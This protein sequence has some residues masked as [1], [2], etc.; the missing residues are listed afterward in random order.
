MDTGRLVRARC[1]PLRWGRSRVWAL[2]V[3]LMVPD[4]IEG[5]AV[6]SEVAQS[7]GCL[8]CRRRLILRS[9]GG[10]VVRDSQAVLPQLVAAIWKGGNGRSR[11]KL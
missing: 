6:K 2:M 8:D 5:L 7:S 11:S 1:G 3:P 10:V 9:A 4:S